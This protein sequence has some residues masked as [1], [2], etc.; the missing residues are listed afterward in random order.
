MN[1][2]FNRTSVRQFEDREVEQEKIEKILQAGFA[3][4]SA[5]NERPFEF[6]VVT[7]KEKILALA[8]TSKYSQPL[9]N[10][11]AAIVICANTSTLKNLD[12]V[13]I[14]CAI[15]AENIWLEVEE[16]GLGCVLLAVHPFADRAAVVAKVLDLPEHIMP[17][18]IMPFGY[19]KN[20]R[21]A[22]SRYNPERVHY[23]K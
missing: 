6:F 13:D 16:L 11:P 2:I 7:N 17:F 3:A 1:A 14:N 21:A 8:E 5:L 12:F 9:K 23:V 10:A 20:K 22:Q 4:P 18:G 15:A 19:P